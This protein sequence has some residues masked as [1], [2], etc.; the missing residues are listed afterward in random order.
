MVTQAE[1]GLP[2]THEKVRK[3][4][5]RIFIARKDTQPL[6]KRWIN[7]FLRRHPSIQV[8]RP[9]RIDA[10]RVNGAT[11]EKIRGWWPKLNLPEVQSISPENRWNM[12]EAGVVEG[13]GSNGLVLGSRYTKALL[14]KQPG[15]RGWTTFIERISATGQNLPPL[16]IFKG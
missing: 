16:V 14:K 1:L 13:Q 4:A 3:L 6:G 2:P 12:D 5:S 10:I 9:Q 8:Q 15:N 7:V 11:T